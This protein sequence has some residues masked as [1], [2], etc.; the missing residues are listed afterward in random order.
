MKF[1]FKKQQLI[2]YFIHKFMTDLKPL[3]KW[4]GGKRKEIKI[5]KEYYPDFIKENNFRYIEPFFGGGSVYWS[6]EL[7]TML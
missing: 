1:S 6:L 2:I 4:T 5:F 7:M 3:F